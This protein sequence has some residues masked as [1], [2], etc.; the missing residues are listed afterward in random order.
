MYE[1]ASRNKKLRYTCKKSNNQT[2]QAFPKHLIVFG[3]LFAK[4][5]QMSVIA[6][7]YVHNGL[8]VEGIKFLYKMKA[9]GVYPRISAQLT[10]YSLWQ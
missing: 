6:C 8:Y 2:C 1:A 5:I 4:A 9:T 3:P 7:G 10:E